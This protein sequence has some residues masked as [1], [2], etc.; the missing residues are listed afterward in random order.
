MSINLNE[1]SDKVNKAIHAKDD[2][3]L[4]MD[5]EK[6]WG[7]SALKGHGVNSPAM[8]EARK[9]IKVNHYNKAHSEEI[10]A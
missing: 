1:K 10:S 7:N 5:T 2:G 3:H 8:M 4:G 9:A 6:R